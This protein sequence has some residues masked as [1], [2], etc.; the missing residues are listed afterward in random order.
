MKIPVLES[1]VNKVAGR[2]VTLLKKDPNTGVFCEIC[3]I[4]KNTFF[5][6]TPLLAA[7]YSIFIFM[8]AVCKQLVL[9]SKS[10]K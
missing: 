5:Y 1:L 3:E 4:L 9:R 7:S 2:P 10:V 6:R 8:E